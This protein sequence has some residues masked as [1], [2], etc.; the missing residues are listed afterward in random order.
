MTNPKISK[1]TPVRK[2]PIHNKR[3]AYNRVFTLNRLKKILRNPITNNA[4]PIVRQICPT[5]IKMVLKNVPAM[6]RRLDPKKGTTIATN[7][8][9]P[10][11]TK[12]VRFGLRCL[13]RM[14]I[15]FLFLAIDYS[16]DKVFTLLTDQTFLKKKFASIFFL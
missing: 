10:R 14:K 7:P 6:Y 12:K 8:N 13:R 9:I 15:S 5:L 16:L 11:K 2:A 3:T 4:P 1:D